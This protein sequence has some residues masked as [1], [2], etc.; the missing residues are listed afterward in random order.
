MITVL[1]VDDQAL[2]R[3]GHRLHLESQPDVT[4]VG[5]AATSQEAISL[6]AQLR[7]TVAVL[8]AHQD[9]TDSLGAIRGLTT[10]EEAASSRPRPRILLLATTADHA[11]ACAALAA[12]ADGFLLH[13]ALPEE[14]TAAVRALAAGHAMISPVL[15]RAL[16][17]TVLQ[18]AP[19]SVQNCELGT[20]TAREREVLTAVATGASNFEI[21]D[22]LSI[23][24]TTV[25]CHVS[26]I[27]TKIGAR[28]RVQA[29]IFAYETGLVRPTPRH[30][31]GADHP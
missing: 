27:L 5:E 24:R 13:D 17:D 28:D 9:F 29:V 6:A 31:V 21:A 20:L 19:T 4:V 1:V 2:R 22:H 30:L 25:K 12:G 7:P 10:S 16:I 23:A 26:S 14:L 15:T 18:Y 8:S 11:Q 3:L